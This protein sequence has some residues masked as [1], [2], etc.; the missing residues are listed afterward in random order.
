MMLATLIQ[1]RA[2][3]SATRQ[4]SNAPSPAPP[5]SSGITMP[6]KPSSPILS[7]NDCGIVSFFGSSSLATGRTSLS[8]KSRAIRR[9]ISRSGVM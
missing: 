5:Y 2:S 3:S 4:Y 6:K 8:V 1:P 9:S 7:I